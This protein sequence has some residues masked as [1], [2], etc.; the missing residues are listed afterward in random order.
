MAASRAPPSLDFG[1]RNDIVSRFKLWKQRCLLFGQ[2]TSQA[3][4]KL[5]PHILSGLDDAGLTIY[6]SFELS[7]DDS[8]DP[9]KIFEKFEERLKIA[10]PNFR[11]KRLEFR[12]LHQNSDTIDEFYTRLMD[13]AKACE[14]GPEELPERVIEQ[15]LA[16]TTNPEFRK[17]I[18]E[19]GKELTL[20]QVLHRGREIESIQASME[21]L[22]LNETQ[23]QAQV[24]AMKK[25]TRPPPRQNHRQ[26]CM[27]CGSHHGRGTECP[28]INSVCNY[29]S[30][31][32]HWEKVCIK[33]KKDT[34]KGTLAHKKEPKEHTRRHRT[35]GT[36][37]KVHHIEEDTGQNSDTDSD[38][39]YDEILIGEMR[40]EAFA[41]IQVDIPHR[42]GRHML[43]VKVDT[44]AQGNTLPLRI[45]KKMMPDAIGHDGLPIPARIDA[46]KPRLTA[47]NGTEIPC[48]GSIQL[49]CKRGDGW[50]QSRFYI[51]DVDSAAISGFGL[52]Q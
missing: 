25:R 48:L 16:T 12:T 3:G 7:D 37:K 36:G 15:F 8:K 39:T 17:W 41:K 29:C 42:K 32:G 34:A 43:S 23:S 26:S 38:I 50:I 4:E 6:N 35:R 45:M 49:R 40:N 14:F 52:S 27:R 2:I 19:Q 31:R 18:I 10:K 28:A 21:Q 5:V 30:T 1:D 33:K 44:G 20:A 24:N 51:V 13:A 22:V 46:K 47:Y 11:S 9:A